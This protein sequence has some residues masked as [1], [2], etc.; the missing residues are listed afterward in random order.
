MGAPRHLSEEVSI[1]LK[2]P[3]RNLGN[4]WADLKLVNMFH[5]LSL[6][7]KWGGGANSTED[8][9]LRVATNLCDSMDCMSVKLDDF[10][11]DNAVILENPHS[12]SK[13]HGVSAFP[14][15]KAES[16]TNFINLWPRDFGF[17]KYKDTW[18][19]LFKEVFKMGFSVWALSS[20]AIPSNDCRYMIKE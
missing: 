6:S 17:S 20:M 18:F 11:L 2:S 8:P 19:M 13:T 12:P 10:K 14:I 9:R 4:L 7:C 1:S 3:M 16:S 5:K 15:S